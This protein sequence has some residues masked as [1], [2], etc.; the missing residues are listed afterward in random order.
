MLVYLS[1]TCVRPDND[2]KDKM[3]TLPEQGSIKISK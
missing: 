1:C 2:L 3:A